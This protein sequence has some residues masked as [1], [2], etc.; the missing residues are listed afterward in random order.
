MR[1]TSLALAVSAGVLLS[2]AHAA[3]GFG[4]FARAATSG[5]TAST[6]TESDPN[7][8]L[9]WL[10]TFVLGQDV[11]VKKSDAKSAGAR[12]TA[13]TASGAPAPT[14][15]ECA[16]K[17]DGKCADGRYADSQRAPQPLPLAF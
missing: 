4:D 2:A 6:K 17:A 8:V 16:P 1:K 9:K 3:P 7:T 12:V 14:D 13:P 11:E 5:G 15:A 10:R